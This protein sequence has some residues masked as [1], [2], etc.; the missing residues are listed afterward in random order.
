MDKTKSLAIFPFHLHVSLLRRFIFWIKFIFLNSATNYP[1]D[2][3]MPISNVQPPN[4][5][6]NYIERQENYIEQLE[7]ES[8]FCRVSHQSTM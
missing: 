7:K 4:E 1:T 5:L 6:L 8:N 2:A 3:L